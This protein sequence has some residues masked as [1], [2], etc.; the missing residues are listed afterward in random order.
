M[1]INQKPIKPNISIPSEFAVNGTKTD[2]TQDKISN[3]F[4]P[5]APDILSGDNLNKF[6]DD[7]YKG[8]TYSENMTDYLDEK[9]DGLYRNIGEIV[10]SALPLSDTSLHLLDGSLLDGNGIYAEFVEYIGDLYL[11][12]QSAQYFTDEVSWQNMAAI[13]G[14]CGKFVYNAGNNTVRLPKISNILQAT[15]NLNALG[16]L[17]Q[18]GLPTL[19]HWHSGT[20]NNE[21]S[22][23]HTRGTMEIKGV[24]GQLGSSENLSSGAVA[25]YDCSHQPDTYG[26][27]PNTSYSKKLRNIILTASKG[28][29]GSTSGGSAH[30]HAFTTGNSS[31]VNS[32]Y[33][34]STTVQPQTVQVLVYMVVATGIKPEI[35]IDIDNL[36][37]DLNNKAD[38]D[39]TNLAQNLS[40]S[41]KAYFGKLGMPSTR[42]LGISLPSTGS[43][44]TM[45]S[46]GWLYCNFRGTEFGK[47][48][49]ELQN[50][51]R[52]VADCA[53]YTGGSAFA[54][55]PVCRGDIVG[56]WYSNMLS[57]YNTTITFVYSIGS[58][59]EAA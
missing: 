11:S 10:Y 39:G 16:E 12:N 33:G 21:S 8:L 3:G 23:T 40:S 5:V 20:T 47:G 9:V 15:T 56:I 13:T 24:T 49:L 26:F 19:Q 31:S 25:N 22:H 2:F 41:A 27:S 42:K 59:S 55:I 44:L 54:S 51:T 6:I 14:S 18:A 35:Q 46:D 58:E 48:Q 34:R 38:K 28:W 36:S 45:P 52:G 57:T 32:I 37:A 29:T 4:D 53:S 1:A 30:N 43:Q 17:I 50:I 7:T